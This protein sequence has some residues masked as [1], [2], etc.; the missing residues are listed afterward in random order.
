M[1][2]SIFILLVTYSWYLSANEKLPELQIEQIDENVFLHQSYSR[3]KGFGLVSSNGLVVVDKGKAFIIDTPWSEQD[4]KKLVNWIQVNNY[5]LLGSI[6]THSHE[7]RTSGIKWLNEISVA[8][9]A[10][11]LT[12]QRLKKKNKALAKHALKE[13]SI[14]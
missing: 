12:N 6:A 8:T 14:S 5:E 13:N 2:L 11:T 10:T 1:R 9:Y 4:T 3:V 7:D